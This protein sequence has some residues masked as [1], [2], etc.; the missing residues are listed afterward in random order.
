MEELWISWSQ[1]KRKLIGKEVVFFGAGEWAEKTL[2][3]IDKE[4][5]CILDNNEIMQN[6]I[7]AGVDVLPVETLSEIKKDFIIL[8]TTGSY[9]NIIKK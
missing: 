9:K 4:P 8:I 3:K 2:R 1:L 6:T 5:L 7:Y